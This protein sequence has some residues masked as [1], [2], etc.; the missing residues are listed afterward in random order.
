MDGSD[1]LD[2]ILTGEALEKI[3]RGAVPQGG[4]H[5]VIIVKGGQNDH[6]HMRKAFFDFPGAQNP[7]DPGHADIQNR[8]IHRH[9]TN[10]RQSLGS[11]LGCGTDMDVRFAFQHD[12]QRLPDHGLVVCKDHIHSRYSPFVNGI[13]AS[14][15]KPSDPSKSSV[16]CREETFSSICVRPYP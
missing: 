8:H 10:E 13:R 12:F 14:V 16:P 5:E 1:R 15:R 7:V 9:L 4:I 3:A 2:Q 6:L 11:I